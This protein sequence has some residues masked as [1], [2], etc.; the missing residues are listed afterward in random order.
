MRDILQQIKWA[1]QRVMRNYDDRVF[2]G[3]DSE[4]V[5]YLKPIR[6]FCNQELKEDY[7]QMEENK[8]R[9]EIL[10]KTLDLLG[11]LE[12]DKKNSAPKFWEHFGKNIEFFWD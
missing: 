11:S 1:Y 10:L 6:Q 12:L 2:W 8:N 9:K 4:F 7:M 5:T 3:F